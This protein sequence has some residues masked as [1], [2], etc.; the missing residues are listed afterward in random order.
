MSIKKLET[1]QTVCAD[2]VFYFISG[3]RITSTLKL[4]RLGMKLRRSGCRT[5]KSGLFVPKL[6]AKAEMTRKRSFSPVFLEL[7]S[8]IH[9][10][11]FS[12]NSAA[13]CSYKIKA[14]LAYSGLA[15]ADFFT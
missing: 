5:S 9:F 7:D 4:T 8:R 1:D 14:L 3:F 15:R 10:I 12:L 6:K 13:C 2:E 11:N